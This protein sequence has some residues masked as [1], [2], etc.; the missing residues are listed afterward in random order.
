M[1]TLAAW[2][3]TYEALCEKLRDI[4]LGCVLAV[5]GSTKLTGNRPRHLI[6]QIIACTAPRKVVSGGADGIDMLS[7]EVAKAY[8]IDWQEFRP[9][10]QRW[11][12]PTLK[13]FAERNTEVATVCTAL[14]RIAWT[15]SK[16]YGSGWTR[17][18]AR[19]MGKPTA[20]FWLHAE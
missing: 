1:S 5:V 3:G 20:E 4:P 11:T 14:V 9:E 6:R 7:V 15:G 13:G 8:G 16:T 2:N 10:V 18:R 17:D 12:H 19:E